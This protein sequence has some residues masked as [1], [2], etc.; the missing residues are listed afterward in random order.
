MADILLVEDEVNARQVLSMGLETQG[1][2]IHT[3]AGPDEAR[4]ALKQQAFDLVLTDLRMEG[5]DAG[6]EVVSMAAASQPRPKILLITA[7][8]STETA[9]DAMRLGAF[10]Y[11]TKP[12]SMDELHEAVER[13]LHSEQASHDSDDEVIASSHD[14]LL[15]GTS[16]VMQRVRERLQRAAKRDFTVLITGESGTGKEVAAR[17]VHLH[18][19]RSE[20]AFI[21]VHCA[22]IPEG[23]FES[24]LFGHC[25]GAFT[26][27]DADR[28]GLVEAAN[29][30]TL[31]L[32]EI[33]EMPLNIQVK[34]LRL[35]QEHSFRRVGE[36]CERHA[37]VRILAAT[38][39]DLIAEV[40]DGIF[41]E[42]L[43]YRLNVV[44][45]HMP[46]L[47]QR[48][49][50]IP[51]LITALLQRMGETITVD[52][53]TIAQLAELPLKGNVRELENLLQ[54]LLALSDG[55]SLDIS[56][57]D[58]F[59][60][61]HPEKETNLEAVSLGNGNLDDALEGVER[62]L[63]EQAMERTKQNATLA[64]KELGITFRSIRYRLKK[65]GIKD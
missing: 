22:A 43:F 11:L 40:R 7:Y 21:P 6:L 27:A 52:D 45:V 61:I 10:D 4:L 2:R 33:G 24:E 47:R 53:E 19:P 5:R 39:R 41:R 38:N 44:P 50:D 26:S 56:I 35:L 37:N 28:K 14:G 25:K 36:D 64:A 13:A 65:L 54:R 15:I 9:V 29:G 58:D 49:E 17:F 60:D 57:L 42:D 18:S 59:D 8:A 46:S 12:V 63:I 1:H 3:C 30:G 16:P 55:D 20:Q 31:F 32:D 62:R 23:L 34:L 48:R 51:L